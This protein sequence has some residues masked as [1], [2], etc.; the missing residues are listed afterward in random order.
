MRR[1]PH[2]L[3]CGERVKAVARH[4]VKSFH[5]GRILS[6][7]KYLLLLVIVLLGLI[8][9]TRN[10]EPVTFDF[11]FGSL[12]QPLSLLLVLTLAIGALLGVM[13]GL[14]SLFSVKRKLR[15]LR[16]KANAQLTAQT[17]LTVTKKTDVS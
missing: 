6:L 10:S 12:Q 13:A 17:G 3:Y 14:P 5:M 11:Y 8:L 16:R 1:C 7:L 15:R 4:E 9:H 2:L